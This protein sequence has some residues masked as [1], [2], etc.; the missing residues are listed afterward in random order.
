MS[1]TNDKIDPTVTLDKLIALL[2]G[3]RDKLTAD[4]NSDTISRVEV[5]GDTETQSKYYNKFGGGRALAGAILEVDGK[6]DKCAT[7]TQLAAK[8]DN[9][10]VAI[11]NYPGNLIEDTTIEGLAYDSWES[12]P[13]E[14][15][16][17]MSASE[18][19]KLWQPG[20]SF[21]I[22]HPGTSLFVDFP[23]TGWKQDETDSQKSII[24]LRPFYAS[25]GKLVRGAVEAQL[26]TSTNS[27]TLHFKWEYAQMG[28]ESGG[29]SG[30]NGILDIPL[31]VSSFN[32]VRDCLASVSGSVVI[33]DS[34]TNAITNI[35]K[36]FCNSLDYT[37]IRIRLKDED[38]ISPCYMIFP[39]ATVNEATGGGFV[40]NF[41]ATGNVGH[42]LQFGT[43]GII[44]IDMDYSDDWFIGVYSRA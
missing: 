29:K 31:S 43:S 38:A 14:F 26:S 4:G 7:K 3:F 28:S 8:A 13:P 23:I 18:N 41:E 24:S 32:K 36:A 17:E 42:G 35:E 33:K 16:V 12:V 1:T 11:D 10:A 22:P 27:Y 20:A 30:G 15:E 19:E 44:S 21:T 2:Q 40:A 39:I 34:E 9:M 5:L 25:D 37:T 6:V